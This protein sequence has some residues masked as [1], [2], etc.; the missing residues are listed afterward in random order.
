[1]RLRSCS[2]PQVVGR[3]VHRLGAGFLEWKWGPW[4]LASV[5]AAVVGVL[6]QVLSENPDLTCLDGVSIPTNSSCGFGL[7]PSR[8]LNA[9]STLPPLA[10][11]TALTTAASMAG[12]ASLRVISACCSGFMGRGGFGGGKSSPEPGCGTEV[13]VLE[14]TLRWEGDDGI[15]WGS[16]SKSNSRAV[17]GDSGGPVGFCEWSQYAYHQIS[18]HVSY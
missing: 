15:S 10:R 3:I 5:L 14:G 2:V 13:G 7:R 16:S 1:M 12:K 4:G 18:A 9:G 11:K 6:A 8:A 17:V